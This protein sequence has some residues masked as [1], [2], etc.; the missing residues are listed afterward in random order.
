MKVLHCLMNCIMNN[1]D[2]MKKRLD[3][4]GGDQEHRMIQD[5]YRTLQRT[6]KY[7][8]QAE[9]V[10][11]LGEEVRWRALINADK[12]K[13]DYDD[14]ILSI[15]FASKFM[16][17]DIFE[18][19]NT[20]TKWL[21]YLPHSTE[22]AYFRAE[23]RRC[24][25]E[26]FWVDGKEKKSSWCYIQGPVETKIDYLQK[27]GIS[28]DSP[29]WSLEIL[30]P[31]NSD[32]KKFFKRYAR[33][34]FDDMA[35]EVQVVDD[36]SVEGILQITALEYYKDNDKDLPEESLADAFEIKP[37]REK[38]NGED[39]IH[40]D[41]IIKPKKSYEY[42]ADFAGGAWSIKEKRPITLLP[43]ADQRV[44]LIWNDVISGNFTL[45]YTVD[46]VT[47]EKMI[48]VESLF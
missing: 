1:L 19:L 33:F 5:K 29:N 6:L 48:V 2:L 9:D 13:E 36:I 39:N 17:G 10:R 34:L 24:K 43:F 21:V 28:L 35:W 47:Y 23:I 45:V 16:P 15:D 38:K 22:N 41:E 30:I 12:E 14:K 40:G 46:D 44:K 31:N 37:A 27:S 32:T 8:V 25:W 7:S 42:G 11:K 4:Q 18:W 3:W 20:D 26:L